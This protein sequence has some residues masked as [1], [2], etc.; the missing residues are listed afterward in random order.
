MA[1]LWG[2]QTTVH[3]PQQG[4][5]WFCGLSSV[6]CGLAVVLVQ[7]AVWAQDVS[8]SAKADKTTVNLG[9]PIQL[10][11]TLIGDTEG[12][13]LPTPEFPEDFAVAA[14]SQSTN[15]SIHAGAMERSMSLLYVLIP[16]RAGTF[17]L[18]PFSLIHQKKTLQTEPIQ[19]TVE[20]GALPKQLQ[21]HGERFTL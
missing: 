7:A 2:R 9:D 21:P 15:F 10:T 17:Q 8:F 4:K 19:V 12:V 20:K 5:N 14:R 6:V 16:Q 1:L 18:G 3:R 13:E 11:L